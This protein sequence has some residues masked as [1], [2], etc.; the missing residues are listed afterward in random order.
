MTIQKYDG[1][2]EI[3]ADD[4]KILTNGDEYAEIVYLADSDSID[5]WKEIDK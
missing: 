1:K 4:G 2:T 5:N 3:Y